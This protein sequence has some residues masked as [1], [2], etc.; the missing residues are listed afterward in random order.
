MGSDPTPLSPTTA[1]TREEAYTE[2]LT[3]LARA[4]WK[5]VLDVQAPYR[6]NLRRLGL[7]RTLDLGCGIGRNLVAL[8]SGS[9]GVDHNPHSVR[10]ARS[11]N[12]DAYEP[13][14]FHAL[15]HRTYQRH[16]DT[17]LLAHVAEHL[18]PQDARQLLTDY[19]PYLRPG[20]TLVLICPQEAGYRS[21][22]SHVTFQ[23]FPRMRDL[24]ESVGATVTMQL[25]FPFPRFIGRIFRYNEFLVLGQF[26]PR[27]SQPR[28]PGPVR[29]RPDRTAQEP[30]EPS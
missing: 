26:P 25:S 30:P 8:P 19:L 4:R 11:Q 7:G 27:P 15:A 20:A 23:D 29:T 5:R 14:E 17:L 22:A 18:T 13:E 24:A 1:D 21:D 2:R 10:I 9:V 6:W 12:L 16:F 28:P 3:T